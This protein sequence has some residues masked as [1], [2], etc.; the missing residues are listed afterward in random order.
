MTGTPSSPGGPP[1]DPRPG[2]TPADAEAPSDASDADDAASESAGEGADSSAD[3]CDY[4]G[5]D[6]LVW[7]KCKLV[8]LNCGQINKSCSD[9]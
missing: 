1:S 5:S 8:C 6:Q 3:V 2:A 9:L 7:R 4:C